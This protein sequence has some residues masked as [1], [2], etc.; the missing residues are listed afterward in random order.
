MRYQTKPVAP[1]V[2]DARQF[3]DEAAAEDLAEWCDAITYTGDRHGH[4]DP[5]WQMHTC[6]TPEVTGGGKGHADVGDWIVK[7]ADDTIEVL[8]PED[9]AGEFEPA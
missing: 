3:T 4:T 5:P 7:H 1:E 9:F 6:I 8:P 2:V